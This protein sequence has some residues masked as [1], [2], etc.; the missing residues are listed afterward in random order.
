MVSAGLCALPGDLVAPDLAAGTLA[1]VPPRWEL[2]AFRAH[3]VLPSDA[4]VPRRVRALIDFLAAG[5]QPRAA[6][7]GASSAPRTSTMRPSSTR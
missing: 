4:T 1:R 6:S 2:P 3:T 5:L 7:R